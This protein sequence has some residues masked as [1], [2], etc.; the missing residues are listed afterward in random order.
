MYIYIE[1]SSSQVLFNWPR[2][3]VLLVYGRPIHKPYKVIC[4]LHRWSVGTVLCFMH[5]GRSPDAARNQ[6]KLMGRPAR[7]MSKQTQAKSVCKKFC[8][9]PYKYV[10]FRFGERGD[11]R[12]C[13][14]CVF[15]C[16]LYLSIYIFF[17]FYSFSFL[18]RLICWK[19][20]NEA[21][22]RLEKNSWIYSFLL[23]TG[24]PTDYPAEMFTST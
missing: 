1:L 5:A 13:K 4:F 20:K 2:Y 8:K 19:K 11:I 14:C 9:N 3:D 21:C 22:F 16:L 24:Q 10:P 6:L 15:L 23:L 7:P 12:F 17:Y 18:G